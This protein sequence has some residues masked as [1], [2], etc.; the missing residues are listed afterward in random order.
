MPVDARTAE[1]LRLALELREESAGRFDPEREDHLDRG[2]EGDRPEPAWMLDGPSVVRILRRTV[3]DLDG[4]AKGYAVDRAVGILQSRGIAAT[5]NA[6]GDLRTSEASGEP[7]L[8]RSPFAPGGL[9]SI[10][11]LGEGAFA[12]S[13]SSVP[14]GT[15]SELAGA[16]IFD[17]RARNGQLP[18][19][20]VS[21]AAPTCAVADALDQSRRG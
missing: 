1:V 5:V 16:G 17:R 12:T 4:I 8:V 10:G 14:T 11:R 21:V 15:E 2:R 6:G 3:L 9:V 7:L 20:S 13:Q 18:L 19:M